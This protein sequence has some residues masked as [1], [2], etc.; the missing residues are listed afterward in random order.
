MP[1]ICQVLFRCWDTVNNTVNTDPASWS[2]PSS[3]ESQIVNKLYVM[4][5]GDK[6]R[7][8]YVDGYGGNLFY[9]YS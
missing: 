3:G 1:T 2:L 6:R 4:A 8:S 9:M 5:S 7:M